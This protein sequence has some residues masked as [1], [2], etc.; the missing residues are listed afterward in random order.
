[1]KQSVDESDAGR[2]LDKFLADHLDNLSRTAIQRAIKSGAAQVNGEPAQSRTILHPG[3]NVEFRSPDLTLAPLAPED[4]PLTILYEDD[5]LAAVDKPSGM[6]VHPAP[7]KATGTLAN[8]LLY[9]FATLS[10]HNDSDRPGIVHRLDA[11]TS[12]VILIAKNN[13]A[14]RAL[15]AQFEQHTVEKTYMAVV[16]GE[17]RFDADVIQLPLGRHFKTPVKQAVRVG[18][19]REAQTAYRVLERFGGFAWL[20]VSPRT[21]RTHQIRVHLANQQMPVLC[22]ATYGRRKSVTASQLRG[23]AP[24][25]GE[26]PILQRQAL[27]AHQIRFNHPT[28]QKEVCLTADIPD[29]LLQVLKVLRDKS[30]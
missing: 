17:A 2:R 3:D 12:G 13:L 6:M 21:G 5:D 19:G 4:I 30:D 27:H 11:D 28:T 14:H 1:M 16:E 25:P 26:K 10:Q 22:D 23:R 20:E 8:A 24:S 29:D 9:H 18:D 7:G 15:A